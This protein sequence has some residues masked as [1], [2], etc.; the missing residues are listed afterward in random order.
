MAK[1]QVAKSSVS[2]DQAVELALAHLGEEGSKSEANGAPPAPSE[3][4]VKLILAY[5]AKH[6]DPRQV[7]AYLGDVERACKS[8]KEGLKSA[9][10][11]ALK[12]YREA[13]ILED[14]APAASSGPRAP[15][16]AVKSAAKSNASGAKAESLIVGYLKEHKGAQPMRRV[17]SELGLSK[18]AFDAAKGS[19]RFKLSGKAGGAKIALA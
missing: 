18:P 1:R 7:L 4:V 5:G 13:G 9:A 10:N 6:T 11:E 14:E 2:D 8:V 3:T 19:D 17:R 12:M 16:K 15:R